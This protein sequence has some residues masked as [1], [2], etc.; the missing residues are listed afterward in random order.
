MRSFGAGAVDGLRDSR[1]AI[2]RARAGTSA[3]TSAPSRNRAAVAFRSVGGSAIASEPERRAAAS[4]PSAYAWCSGT[5]S[6]IWSSPLRPS[7]S[8]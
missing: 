2:S 8:T 7:V 6:R 3:I 5:G 4:Q 1:I